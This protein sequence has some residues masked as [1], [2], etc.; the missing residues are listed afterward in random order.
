M[1]VVTEFPN[2]N[3]ALCWML[4]SGNVDGSLYFE[5]SNGL[6]NHQNINH[7]KLSTPFHTIMGNEL[8][9]NIRSP[10]TPNTPTTPSTPST[11]LQLF[12]HT[13]YSPQLLS[14][15]PDKDARIEI[16]NKKLP[17]IPPSQLALFL[18]PSI[19]LKQALPFSE[20]HRNTT[21]KPYLALNVMIYQKNREL[22][23]DY[24]EAP[25]YRTCFVL[26]RQA[27]EF[28]SNGLVESENCEMK[29]GKQF[30]RRCCIGYEVAVW[31]SNEDVEQ[32]LMLLSRLSTEWNGTRTYDDVDC[33]ETH[34]VMAVLEAMKLWKN[35]LSTIGVV[36]KYLKSVSMRK[37]F[38]LYFTIPRD[39]LS[40]LETSLS[41][42]A[43]CAW[44]RAMQLFET[45]RS[46]DKYRVISFENISD[47]VSFAKF[48]VKANNQ[49][50]L[51]GDEIGKPS[52]AL[53]S[54]LVWTQMLENG[55][56]S[57]MVA[58]LQQLEP[59][60]DAYYSTKHVVFNVPTWLQLTSISEQLE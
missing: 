31:T 19:W 49:M 14:S 57:E 20:R 1:I 16:L 10:S 29:D 39:T 35:D 34:F 12:H 59:G 33:N 8:T 30:E 25:M 45:T 52:L 3:E 5:Q 48:C 47:L 15:I 4:T 6:P 22:A 28:K 21:R 36:C 40:V 50:Y 27:V 53:L 54:A 26:G 41:S 7:K 44:K 56:H 55:N 37:P 60:Q 42:V 24:D 46:D 23:V 11:P 18:H 2:W 32:N 13:S 43:D 17:S 9:T 38:D 51:K 58:L